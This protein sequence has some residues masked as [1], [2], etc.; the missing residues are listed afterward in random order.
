[1]IALEY[2]SRRFEKMT[3]CLWSLATTRLGHGMNSLTSFRTGELSLQFLGQT[4][5]AVSS[6]RR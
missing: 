1:M 6:A 2:V 4:S 5:M 3:D